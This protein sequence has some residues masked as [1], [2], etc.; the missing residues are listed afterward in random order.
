[1]KSHSTSLCDQNVPVPWIWLP[2]P[3]FQAVR[4]LFCFN[5]QNRLIVNVIGFCSNI[6]ISLEL[7]AV[8][9]AFHICRL[10][11][12]LQLP[13]KGD[14][15]ALDGRWGNWGSGSP[16]MRYVWCGKSRYV[17]CGTHGFWLL[18]SELFLLDCIASTSSV[19][20]YF[21]SLKKLLR[22]EEESCS[23]PS[24]TNINI[25]GRWKWA[26]T[27]QFQLRSFYQVEKPRKV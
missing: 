14:F 8:F 2:N 21:R 7:S 19:I 16:H 18:N 9:K 23:E 12:F 22:N 6:S 27:P 20:K 4:R 24:S 1:M 15:G 3:R 10:M 11:Y 17:G 5:K 25:A 13:F 26:T